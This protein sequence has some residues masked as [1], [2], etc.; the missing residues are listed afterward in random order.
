MPF[1]LVRQLIQLIALL[2]CTTLTN[3][4]QPATAD[5]AQAEP[6]TGNVTGTIVGDRGQPLIGASVTVRRLNV[7][8]GAM[9]QVT[10]N[11]EGN[12]EAR[13]LEVG[14]YTVT[15]SAPAYV[16]QIRDPDTPAP[17]Y[18]IG[19]SV[20]LD[21]IRGGV[22]TGTVTNATSD[23]V[24]SVRV[25][26]LMVRDGNGQ[27]MKGPLPAMGVGV[28]DDRGIYR[29]FGLVPGT[30][31]VEV[32]G[33]NNSMAGVLTPY[34]LDGPTYAPSSTRDN[35]TEVTVSSGQE[36]S[37][38][39]RYRAEPGHTVSGTVK[40]LGTFGS[41]ISLLPAD[42]G[43]IAIA[44]TSQGADDRGFA[45]YGVADGTYDVVAQQRVGA[46]GAAPDI[47]FSDGQRITVKGADVT[48]LE[49]VTK[50]LA[51][52]SGTITLQPSTASECAGKRKPSLAEIMVTIQRNRSS[53]ESVPIIFQRTAAFAAPNK[54][55]S[56]EWKNLVRGQHA[57]IPRFFA[58]YWYLQ[59]ITLTT[60][61]ATS[62]KAALS[63]QKIDVARNWITVKSGDRLT[64]LT[65][66]LAEGAGSLRGRLAV[67]EGASAP[68]NLNVFLVPAEREKADDVLRYFAVDVAADQTFSADNLPPGRYW[69]T[70]QPRF[71]RDKPG[72]NLRLPDAA[73]VRTKLRT[74]AEAHKNEIELKPCQNVS[75]YQLTIQS[76]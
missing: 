10:T 39:V 2:L 72:S 55:G 15:V 21:L 75:G 73:E 42:G 65:I 69:L 18:R 24:V 58:R 70:T 38:D 43:W 23:P 68:Q 76:A 48:G 61:G 46:V 53:A 54:N 9:R 74:A 66:T 8:G 22:I 32:G 31:I 49:L 16:M 13:N 63:N 1:K 30:Y 28:T 57:V 56:M 34:D 3:A 62:A 67:A 44:N 47:T 51:S 25:R 37:V 40:N 27:E 6:T 71:P 29:I 60:V 12:F 52:L 35:A 41:S 36:S 20:R 5:Q 4:Q 11:N 7:M 26:A 45:F 64:G 17:L 19:D 14:L 59:S 33:Y 50:P